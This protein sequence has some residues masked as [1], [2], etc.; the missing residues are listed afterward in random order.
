MTAATAARQVRQAIK[1]LGH[2]PKGRVRVLHT[3]YTTE[4]EVDLRGLTQEERD[5]VE[6]QMP[7]SRCFSWDVF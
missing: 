6:D 5:S 2:N 4:I 7:D 3:D 1:R